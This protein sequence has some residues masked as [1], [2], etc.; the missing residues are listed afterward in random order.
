MRANESETAGPTRGAATPLVTE[1][2]VARALA[3][4]A[5]V[6]VNDVRERGRDAMAVESKDGDE[7]VT[8]ADRMASELIVAGLERAFPDDLVISE[9][10]PFDA[11]IPRGRRVWFVDPIDG[12]RDFIRGA[13][14]FAVMIGLCVDGAPVLGVVYQPTHG[15]TFWAAPGLGAWFC[16][17]DGPPRRLAVREVTEVTHLKLVASASHRSQA[18]DEVKTALGISNEHNIGSVGIKLAL[19]ALGERDLYVNPT[20]RTK[21]WDTCA[22]QAIIE[23][24]GG[25]MTD[26]LG[27]PLSYDRVDLGSP[28]GLVACGRGVHAAV[29]ARLAALPLFRRT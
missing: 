15:G 28:R 23:G 29:L 16:R 27:G 4:D 1:L 26:G 6:I 19:I 7:P 2:R 24:A 9:E 5:G 11:I 3:R 10:R 17:G 18:I 8:I 25:V 14:G 22:P 21:A 13:E 12:T 20:P